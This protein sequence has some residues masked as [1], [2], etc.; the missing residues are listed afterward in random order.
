MVYRGET[1]STF[2]KTRMRSFHARSLKRASAE[3]P[4]DNEIAPNAV[5]L[6]SSSAAVAVGPKV[7]STSFG[8]T[9]P[10]GLPEAGP[11]WPIVMFRAFHSPLFRVGRPR[12]PAPPF[13]PRAAG[14][15]A[16]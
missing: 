4:K 15:A 3:P 2:V 1:C 7:E 14:D 10:A 11:S 16:Y 9:V 6:F 13:V 12:P 8:P 5:A